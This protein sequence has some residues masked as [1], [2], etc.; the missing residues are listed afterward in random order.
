MASGTKNFAVIDIGTNAVKCKLRVHDRFVSLKNEP[1]IRSSAHALDTREVVSC[2]V[3]YFNQIKQHNIDPDRIYICATE[4][5]RQT[6]NREAIKA[7]IFAK[8]GRI[9]HVISPQTEAKLSAIGGLKAIP[10]GKITAKNVLYM[11]SGGGSTEISLLDLSEHSRPKVVS[12]VSIPF[13]S[14]NYQEKNNQ[15][16]YDEKIDDFLLQIKNQKFSID[17][18]CV[19]IINSSTISRVI[20][21]Q[22]HVLNFNPYTTMVKQQ[23]MNFRNLYAKLD[24]ILAQSQDAFSPQTLERY[25]LSEDRADGFI[26][27][28]DIFKNIFKRLRQAKLTASFDKI[29]VATTI[30]GLKDGLCDVIINLEPEDDVEEKVLSVFEA[31]QKKTFSQKTTQQS[32]QDKMSDLKDKVGQDRAWVDSYEQFYKKQN[33]TYECIKGRYSLVVVDKNHNK[34]S[35][36]GKNSVL[37][38]CNKD[39]ADNKLYENMIANAKINGQ[40][41][42]RFNDNVDIETKLRIYSA[43]VKYG[44]QVKN[45]EYNEKKLEGVSEKTKLIV[46]NARQRLQSCKAQR[47]RLRHQQKEPQA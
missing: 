25:Y 29:P 16:I 20:A 40:K 42:V 46:E 17:E 35:Y 12:T 6:P 19:C 24:N 10:K 14:K 2:V 36:T 3:N 8:T 13:G 31:S 21:A 38:A 22:Y 15:N 45:F 23:H 39:C 30:G 47:P 5:F 11:E 44:L 7:E 43:C 41:F 18:N 37:V 4:A 32:A 27:H 26:G 1:L 9:I 28:C 33:S 34:V